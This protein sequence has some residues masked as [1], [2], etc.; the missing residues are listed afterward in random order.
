MNLL[1]SDEYENCHMLHSLDFSVGLAIEEF[2]R[3]IENVAENAFPSPSNI[4]E[5]NREE[6]IAE[7]TCSRLADAPQAK[8]PKKMVSFNK[9]VEEILP[10]TSRRIKRIG[11]EKLGRIRLDQ[12]DKEH[13]AKP[14]KSILKNFVMD[15]RARSPNHSFALSLSVTSV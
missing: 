6:E 2:L 9:S 11:S 7:N 4:E 13:A 5:K 12:K 1:V 8:V 10:N 15:F 3:K 14:L